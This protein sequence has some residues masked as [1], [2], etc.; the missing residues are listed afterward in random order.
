[1]ENGKREFRKAALKRRGAIERRKEKSRAAAE[2]LLASDWYRRASAVFLYLSYQ[3]EAD[4]GRILE[5]A[6]RQ[7]KPVAAPRVEGEKLVFYRICSEEDTKEG[8]RGIREP[9]SG[10]SPL[11]PGRE[12]LILVPG[13]AFDLRGYRM[14]YGGGFYDRF[15]AK[16]RSG[17]V[18]IGFAFEEQVWS[19]IP[20]EA[21]DCRL[22][23]IVT[24]DG[25]RIFSQRPAGYRQETE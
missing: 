14:G 2:Y 11:I 1:M 16:T 15:L 5:Q 17:C 19:K 24:E 25:I 8:Y 9:V 12:D 23:G 4:T 20:T 22:D 18:R 21:H 13:A 7:G 6:W 10:C 3:S